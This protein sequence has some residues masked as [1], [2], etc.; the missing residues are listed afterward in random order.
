MDEIYEE[1]P[2]DRVDRS[3]RSVSTSLA[4]TDTKVNNL[5]LL[6]RYFSFGLYYTQNMRGEGG[7]GCRRRIK[8]GEVEG[9]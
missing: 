5:L 2:D 8:K 6:T 4:G 3:D 7:L 1:I 9:R